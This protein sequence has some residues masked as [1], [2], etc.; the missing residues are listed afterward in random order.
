MR[1]KPKNILAL[2]IALGGMPDKVRVEVESGIEVSAKTVTS[3][4]GGMARESSNNNPVRTRCRRR[5]K[6]E[7][8]QPSHSRLAKT[9]G[10]TR[11]NGHEAGTRHGSTSG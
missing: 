8:G 11:K 7:Q 2:H 1:Y 9:V 6:G 5:R 3:E 10:V 4:G